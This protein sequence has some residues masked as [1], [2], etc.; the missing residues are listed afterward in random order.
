MLVTRWKEFKT[1][2]K[3]QFYPIRYVEDQWIQW[4]Y[5]MK[6]QGQ[7]V[8]EY[9]IESR[10][11]TIMLG[12]SPKNPYVLHK[13]LGGLHSHL[14]KQVILFKPRKMEKACVQAQLLET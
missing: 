13:Y 12:I 11:M 5:F 8:Q 1:L 3:F 9:N 6:R 14:R 2:I 7:N 10:R 4:H